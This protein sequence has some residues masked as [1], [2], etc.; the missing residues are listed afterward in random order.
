MAD[1]GELHINGIDGVTGEYLL[2]PLPPDVVARV[3]G[4]ERLEKDELDELKARQRAS[5]EAYLGVVAGVD[6]T[7]LEESGWGVVF[8]HDIE[9]EVL[10]ALRPLLDHRRAEAAAVEPGRYREYAG[11]DGH[12]PEDR[13]TTF[14]ARHGIA[15]GNPADPDRMPYYLLLVGGP[16]RIPFRFQY[17]LDVS[18]AVGRISFDTAEEY[19]RYAESVVRSEREARPSPSAVFLGTRNADDRATTLSAEHLVA[20][21]AKGLSTRFQDRTFEILVGEEQATKA[22]LAGAFHRETAPAF[23]F[24]ATHGMAFPK[25]DPRQAPHQGAPL[26]QEWPGP[27]QWRQPIPQ[28]FYLAGDDVADDARVDGAVVFL[29]ACYGAGTPQHDDFGDSLGT[30]PEIAP[31][32]FVAGLP[33]RLLGH[34]RGSALAVVGHVERAWGYSFV[35]PGIGSQLQVFDSALTELLRG[36][37]VGHAIEYFSDRYAA[38]TTDLE[39][40]KE[41]AR[42]GGTPDPLEVSGLWTARNDARNYVLLGDPAVR[43]A[44]ASG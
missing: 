8:P 39:A 21:L 30:P 11:P 25:G 2:P 33:R 17:Q 37:P 28:D 15:P 29:F 34:P 20:P 24:T 31:G 10:E 9:P 14:L 36:V 35:W 42:F 3:A 18:F 44:P 22:S 4:G 12:R 43:M 13:S 5:T 41:D 27:L 7:K 16:D 38:L 19:G 26:C 32:A 40:L 6:P 23:V 1:A